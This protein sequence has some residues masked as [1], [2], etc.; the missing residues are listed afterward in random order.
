MTLHLVSGS[1][2][3]TNA[4]LLAAFR[5]EGV[6]AVL[7]TPLEL[8]ELV[9][10]G[11]TVLGRLDVLPTLEGVEP[12]I[13][14]LHRLKNRGVTLFNDPAALLAAHDKLATA[15]RLA[16]SGVRHPRTA[17]LDGQS[18]PL[19]LEPPVVVKPR[20]GSW[21]VDVYVCADQAELTACLDSLRGRPWFERQGVLVQELVPPRG[22]D[23]RV[24][25]ASGQVVGAV[26]RVA[27]QDEWRTNIALGGHRRRC[28][29]PPEACALAVKAAAAIGC[30]LVG[31]DLLPDATGEWVVLELNGAVDFTEEYSL[32]GDSV[33]ADIAQMLMP[34]EQLPLAVAAVS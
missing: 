32:N 5:T 23:L 25:V 7:T 1:L 31:V 9:A 4:S 33:F 12:G 29:P 21:G 16:G 30:D 27:A 8:R 18:G 13:W 26:E 14:E 19:K 34:V 22:Y 28:D 15:I 17:H 11:D 10:P 3:P 24:L 20:F 6:D 2:T